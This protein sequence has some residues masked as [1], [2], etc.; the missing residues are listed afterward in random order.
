MVS[1]DVFKSDAFSMMSMLAAIENVDYN[2]QFLGSLNLFEDAPQRTRVV[3]IESRDSELALI[4]TSALGAPLD[5]RGGDKAKL[6]NFNTTRIAKASTIRADEIQGIRAF[7][8][9]SEL[10]Q[11]QTEVARRQAQLRGDMELTFE[12]HRLGAIQ[13]IVTDADGSTIVNF[14]TEFG[15]AQPAEVEFD[16]GTLS[17]N[18]GVRRKIAD[19]IVRP[20]IRAAKG[21]MTPASQVY[22]LCGDDFFDI[23]TNCAEVRQTYLNHQAAAA[24]REPTAFEQFRYAGVTWVNYRGTDDNST[25]AIASDEAKFFPVGA[26]GIFKVAWAPGESFDVVNT[27]GVPVL[28]MVLLDPSGRNAFVTVE[29]YS[30]PLFVCTRPLTLRRAAVT[31]S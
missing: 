25:V 12:H 28:P 31:G 11:V 1:M 21:A 14:F 20:I 15:V 17:A 22:A 16:F 13:G 23:L 4:Q 6:R 30:Y 7:G 10:K 9:E 29:L 26:P 19:D 24:L 5:Q 18:G 27:P 3:T 2:P 8:S